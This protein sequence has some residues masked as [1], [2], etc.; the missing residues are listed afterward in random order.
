MSKCER[1]E[2]GRHSAR[3][4]SMITEGLTMAHDDT[5]MQKLELALTEAYQARQAP[6]LRTGW[7][8]CTLGDIRHVG[9]QQTHRSVGPDSEQLVWRTAAVAA[10]AFML[11]MTVSMVTWSRTASN[12]EVGMLTEELESASLF[13]D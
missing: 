5:D 2:L 13:P 8:L 4:V 9:I 7:A 3:L 6:R 11:I 12:E 1:I 10:A